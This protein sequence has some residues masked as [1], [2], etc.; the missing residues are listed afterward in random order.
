LNEVLQRP[1]KVFRALAQFVE[2]ARIL[3]GDNC[4]GSKVRD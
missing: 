1:G 4:L 2:Q 3:Y